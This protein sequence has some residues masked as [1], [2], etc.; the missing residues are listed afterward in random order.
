MFYFGVFYLG[1]F[2]LGHVPRAGIRHACI[3]SARMEAAI[4][5]GDFAPYQACWPAKGFKPGTCD[6][7]C[8]QPVLAF[9]M[10]AP[11]TQTGYIKHI[12]RQCRQKRIII[13]FRIVGQGN[14]RRC[15]IRD[16]LSSATDGHSWISVVVSGNRW[17]SANMPRGSMTL[18]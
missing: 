15:R 17:G 2:L 5:A 13:Y 9:G 14:Q 10:G 3:S 6:P 1:V 11:A 12:R 8:R 18:T 7:L 4:S 16:R